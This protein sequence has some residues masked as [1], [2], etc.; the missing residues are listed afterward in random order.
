MSE[1]ETNLTKGQRFFIKINKEMYPYEI[2]HGEL[3][4]DFIRNTQLKSK[5]LLVKPLTW[6]LMDVQTK[7]ETRFGYYK[8]VDCQFNNY[9][10]LIIPEGE[11][12]IGVL[13]EKSVYIKVLN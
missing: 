13:N 6:S 2:T 4:L 7:K 11:I 12:E 5:R 10:K 8:A 3:K 9:E 1:Y